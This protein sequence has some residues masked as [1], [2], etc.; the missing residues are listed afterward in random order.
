MKKIYVVGNSH[1]MYFVGREVPIDAEITKED[2]PYSITAFKAGQ[3]GATVY[4][5]GKSGSMTDAGRK[6]R[7][8]IEKNRPENVIFVLGDVDFRE[9]MVKHLTHGW[10]SVPA[11]CSTVRNRYEEYVR[12]LSIPRVAICGMVP[13]SRHYYELKMREDLRNAA[14][15]FAVPQFNDMLAKMAG[16]NGW[17][18]ISLDGLADAQGFLMP[19]YYMNPIEVHAQPEAA[20]KHVIWK[21]DKIFGQN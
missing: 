20:Y 19:E 4:S 16:D 1:V 6:I 8:K 17:G 2:D 11:F 7:E 21:V 18:F 3:T 9:H 5:L 12:S 13:F 10:E 15:F 14:L